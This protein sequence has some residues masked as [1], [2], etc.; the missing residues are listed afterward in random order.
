MT[1]PL[2]AILMGMKY[3]LLGKMTLACKAAAW[4][5]CGPQPPGVVVRAGG[6]SWRQ[7][8]ISSSLGTQIYNITSSTWCSEL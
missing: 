6:V 8:L 2:K 5:C 1:E 4:A 7:H 3:S